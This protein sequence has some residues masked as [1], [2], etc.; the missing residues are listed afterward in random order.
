M[1]YIKIMFWVSIMQKK[2]CN[3]SSSSI[4]LFIHADPQLISMR[5]VFQK[6]SLHDK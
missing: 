2:I 6:I 3:R 1:Y 4:T 5:G